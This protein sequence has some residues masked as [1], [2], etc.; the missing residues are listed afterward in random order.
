MDTER[1][2]NSGYVMPAHPQDTAGRWSTGA[3]LLLCFIPVFMTVLFGGVDNITWAV[4]PFLWALIVLLWLIGCWR[5]GGFVFDT[6][7]LQLPLIGL[8]AIGLIQLLPLGGS[9]AD[10]L[11]T[12]P[13]SHALS[14]D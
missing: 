14:L 2:V 3:F 4:V 10:D 8:L 6:S 5:S 12:A 1:H 7:S 11:V 13:V 9:G